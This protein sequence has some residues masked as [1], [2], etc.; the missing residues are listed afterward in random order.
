MKQ[1]I[2]LLLCL[3]ALAPLGLPLPAA[4]PAKQVAQET[5][6]SCCCPSCADCPCPVLPEKSCACALPTAPDVAA[7]SFAVKL[8]GPALTALYLVN[9]PTAFIHPNLS[10][11]LLRLSEWK[12]RPPP[13]LIGS[14]P[15]AKLRVWII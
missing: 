6:A 1:W 12:S 3:V 10:P 11:K 13:L 7:G 15:Q 2:A 5:D 14:P 8:S 9:G 4:C